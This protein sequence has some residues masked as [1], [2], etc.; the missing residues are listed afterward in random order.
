[1]HFENSSWIM[2]SMNY[3]EGRIQISLSSLD[4]RDLLADDPG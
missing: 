4:T 1:M 2:D 3:G